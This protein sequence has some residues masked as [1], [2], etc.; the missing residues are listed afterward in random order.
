MPAGWCALPRLDRPGRDNRRSPTCTS[1]GRVRWL[2]SYRENVFHLVA[3]DATMV[4]AIEE[5][6]RHVGENA[7]TGNPMIV[8]GR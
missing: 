2:D 4:T 8:F 5:R 7:M 1:A 3:E 6:R